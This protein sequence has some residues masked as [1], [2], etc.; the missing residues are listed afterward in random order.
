M[1]DIFRQ[2]LGLFLCVVGLPSKESGHT[3]GHRVRVTEGGCS[4]KGAQAGQA[5]G[6][7]P[8]D[9]EGTAGDTHRPA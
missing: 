3:F 5:A 9:G 4:G 7:G 6:W 8:D 1:L 2:M